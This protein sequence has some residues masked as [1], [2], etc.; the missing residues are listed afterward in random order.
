MADLYALLIPLTASLTDVD[1]EIEAVM[2]PLLAKRAGIQA[3]IDEV[4]AKIL[5]SKTAVVAAEQAVVGAPKLVVHEPEPVALPHVPPRWLTLLRLMVAFPNDDFG[6]LAAKRYGQ[7]NRTTRNSLSAEFSG[8]KTVGLVESVGAANHAAF[9]ITPL[10]R[11]V[12]AESA[13]QKKGERRA[14]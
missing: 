3:Q 1:R 7:D 10:G 13:S 9:A 12:V 4:A 8:M 2:G 5:G 11:R 6:A 14:G